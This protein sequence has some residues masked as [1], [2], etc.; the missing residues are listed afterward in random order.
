MNISFDEIRTII[1]RNDPEGL[2]RMGAPE[3]EYDYEVGK[4]YRSLVDLTKNPSF[5]YILEL[6]EYVFHTSFDYAG[7]INGGPLVM[8]KKPQYSWL[9][10]NELIANFIALEIHELI[11]RT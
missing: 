1:L 4:I 3:D 9:H 10:D 5:Q 7:D 8:Y 11:T 2:R 6:V